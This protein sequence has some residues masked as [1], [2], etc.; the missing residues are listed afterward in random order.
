MNRKSLAAIAATGI[1]AGCGGGDS[2]GGGTIQPAA[3]MAIDGSNAVSATA[4]S[5]GAARETAA[6][7]ELSG[8]A[9]LTAGS[10]GGSAKTAGGVFKSGSTTAEVPLPQQTV[11]CDVSGQVIFNID[12]EDPVT[13]TLT[14]GDTF[15]IEFDMCVDTVGESTDGLLGFEVNAFT[16]DFLGGLYD[17]T[18]RMSIT[19]LNIVT[20]DD[21]ILSNGDATVRLDTEQAPY[22]ESSISGRQFTVDANG[23]SQSL[24][25]FS[26]TQTF[27]GTQAPAP[28]TLTAA[29]TVDSTDLPG[30]VRYS[31]PVTFE[32]FD[33]GFPASGELLV[34]GENSAA[35]LIAIND[36]DVR[37]EFDAD[38]DGVF[39]GEIITTWAELASR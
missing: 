19:D 35:K 20:P 21:S 15:D 12:I 10:P 11:P 5:Y 7:G 18:M 27:D 2:G 28:W 25:D 13:P 38:G 32:G 30:S 39:E 16:G 37:I 4:V 1:I 36:V 34:E 8:E 14:A 23:A 22:V 26:S 24:L 33:D 3:L 29:G 9:G 6:L 17:L 31:T